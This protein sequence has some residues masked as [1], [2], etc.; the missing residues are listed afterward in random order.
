MSK[1]GKALISAVKDAKKTGLITL[2]ASSDIATRC[3]KRKHT[4]PPGKGTNHEA[5]SAGNWSK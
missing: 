3:K 5:A 1:L 2:K 4:Y